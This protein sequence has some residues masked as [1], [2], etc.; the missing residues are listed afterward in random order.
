MAFVAPELSHVQRVTR[1][2]RSSLKH[3]LSWCIDRQT[4]RIEALKLRDRF[5]ASKNLTDRREINKLLLEGEAEFE[6]LKHPDPY[7]SE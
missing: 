6:R 4:W 2:Y 5:D 3:L 7:I 1:L